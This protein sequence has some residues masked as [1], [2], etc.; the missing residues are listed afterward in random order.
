[1]SNK[2]PRC[3]CQEKRY[4]YFRRRY[5]NGTLHLLRKCE[6]CGKAAQNAMR[7]DEYDRTWIDGL[8]I[9][10]NG[11]M[12]PTVQSRAEQIQERLRNHIAHRNA[13][14]GTND[15]IHT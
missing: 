11:I 6:Q 2:H 13:K 8:P 4:S 14:Q 9:L 1:M 15:A 3:E 10:E 5:R 12:N 7:Q